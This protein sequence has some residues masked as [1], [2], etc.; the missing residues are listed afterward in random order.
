MRSPTLSELPPPPPGRTGWP[1]TEEAPRLPATLSDGTLWPRLSIVTPSYN[2]QVFLEESLRSVLLQGYPDLEYLVID[3]GS[4]DGT[5]EILERYDPWLTFW[6]S[7]PDRG[8]AHAVNKGLARCS[9]QIVTFFSSDDLYLPGT[10]GTIGARW[11]E[12]EGCGAAT[13]GF[14]HIDESSRQME[15]ELI[16]PRLPAPAPLDLSLVDPLAWRL[17]QVATFYVATALDAVGRSLLEDLPYNA[18]RELLY[19]ICLRFPVDLVPRALA[20]FR[21]HPAS[22]AGGSQRR[23]AA[24]FEY[25]RL[26][27]SYCTGDI[28]DRRRRKIAHHF[29]AKANMSF[30]KYSG[31][32]SASMLAL[33]KALRYRPSGLR[34]NA[35]LKTWL[36]LLGLRP[37]LR[38]DGKGRPT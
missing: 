23:S 18:D 3:G 38:R 37:A 17:H 26:Q 1:W 34:E 11:P 9:G 27:L 28:H 6:S 5:A 7:E 12:L 10:F 33:L 4:H 8:W 21:V 13:G 25:A 16:P 22:L 29:L 24:E 20:A 14:Y 19:R 15:R 30:A 35:Y 36:K 31:R 32:R 2:R